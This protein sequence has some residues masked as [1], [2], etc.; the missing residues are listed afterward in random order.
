MANYYYN[1]YNSTYCYENDGTMNYIGIYGGS[2]NTFAQSESYAV[3]SPDFAG[4]VDG[5]TSTF[6]YSTWPI[7]G[8]GAV[9]YYF[10]NS[11]GT[12]NTVYSGHIIYS[13]L[14]KVVKRSDGN[15][16][17]YQRDLYAGSKHYSK[18]TLLTSNIVAADGT[19]PTDGYHTDGYWYVRGSIIDSTAPV[20]SIS[21]VTTGTNYATNVTPIFSVSDPETSITTYTHT[22]NGTTFTSGTAIT[23]D[24][25]YSLIISATNAAGLISSQT[26]SFVID[27]TAPTINITGVT[28]GTIYTNIIS[29]TFSASDTNGVASCIAT[30]N[31]NAY[32]SGSA[33]NTGGSKTLVVT[34]IDTL[35]NSGSTTITF[36]M[37]LNQAPSAPTLLQ[38]NGS[39]NT[40][41]IKSLIPKFSSIFNDPN[42]V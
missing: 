25:S 36:T 17:L 20:I 33:I 32:T 13:K 8:A 16:D 10:T 30:L 14:N 21:G 28:N 23:T 9:G 24:G 38:I 3:I 26:V 19:Y 15:L 41:Y 18:T 2:V 40:T 29:P 4:Y 22:L 37:N 12:L 1:K 31:G 6:S 35:G 11:M 7:L 5:I 34:T 27:K 39:S 42:G